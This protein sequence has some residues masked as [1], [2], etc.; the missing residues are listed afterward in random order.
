M[1]AKAASTQ[2]HVDDEMTDISLD[3]K[4]HKVRR[5]GMA[6]SD[7]YRTL[8]RNEVGCPKYTIVWWFLLE[9]RFRLMG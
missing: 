2:S 4:D 6:I 9:P 7:L 1:A 8:M 3:H 5:N